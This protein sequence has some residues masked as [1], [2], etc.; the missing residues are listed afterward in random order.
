MNGHYETNGLYPLS[1]SPAAGWGNPNPTDE[2]IIQHVNGK[3]VKI[4]GDPDCPINHGTLCSK[5]L[6]SIQLAY[7]PERLTHPVRR[8]GAKGSGRGDGGMG[9][10]AKGPVPSGR[11][12]PVIPDHR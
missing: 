7:H 9:A 10:G 2:R 12:I 4:T 11:I 3:A 1:I 6:A 8:I 5:G